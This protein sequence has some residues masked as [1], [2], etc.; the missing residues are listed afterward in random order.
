MLS[1]SYN[2]YAS[3]EHKVVMGIW[4]SD[5]W[6]LEISVIIEE[7]T[8]SSLRRKQITFSSKTVLLGSIDFFYF[9]EV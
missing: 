3:I 9:L 1:F 5:I 7:D 2:N 6:F 4:L 8:F